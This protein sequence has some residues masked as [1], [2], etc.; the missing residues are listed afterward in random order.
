[1]VDPAAPGVASALLG[2]GAEV[3]RRHYDRGERALAAG[4]YHEGLERHAGKPKA[5]PAGPGR[6][7]AGAADLP[8]DPTA[9]RDARR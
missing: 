6:T 5:S 4:R 1:L 9:N 7:R 8:R 2:I 3:H